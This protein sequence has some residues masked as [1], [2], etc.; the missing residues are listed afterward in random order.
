MGLAR[1]AAAPVREDA[2][3]EL[4]RQAVVELFS[5]RAGPSCL[6][7]LAPLYATAG[8]PPLRS[9]D[10]C[11]KLPKEFRQACLDEANGPGLT[12]PNPGA[13]PPARETPGPAARLS[14][15]RAPL[16]SPPAPSLPAFAAASAA[17]SAANVPGLPPAKP[18][19]RI[20]LPDARAD[21]WGASVDPRLPFKPPSASDAVNA[22]KL[23]QNG[24]GL[25]FL[26]LGGGGGG[27]A[28][29]AAGAAPGALLETGA[30]EPDGGM[31]L[32]SLPI[33]ANEGSRQFIYSLFR[34]VVGA[35]GVVECV[36]IP[37]PLPDAA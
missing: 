36:D 8:A 23:A 5:A 15:A 28:A 14:R 17:A 21:P 25:T 2:K 7:V 34:G 31:V 20:A 11:L 13:W 32:A 9:Q 29:D 1:A 18:P 12:L 33:C 22:D 6:R 35:L 4:N 27:G 30:G 26:E 16:P 24:F 10:K 19:S 37:A 3:N